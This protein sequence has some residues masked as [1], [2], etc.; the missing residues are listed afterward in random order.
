MLGK[1]EVEAAA[2]AA[3]DLSDVLV[4]YKQADRALSLLQ[5]TTSGLGQGDVVRG[6][7]ALKI[8][9]LHQIA[10]NCDSGPVGKTGGRA[11]NPSARWDSGHSSFLPNY[12]S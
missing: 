12:A 1:R 2:L 4:E 6:I 7:A 11:Q 3:L 9:N 5:Q 8:G 10:G